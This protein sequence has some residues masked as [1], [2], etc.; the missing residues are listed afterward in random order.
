MNQS[1]NSSRSWLLIF[2]M[3]LQRK[4]VAT[5]LSKLNF[6]LHISLHYYDNSKLVQQTDQMIDL[7]EKGMAKYGQRPNKN[8]LC[9]S[10][11][12]NF[13]EFNDKKYINYI[14]T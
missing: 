4:N 12:H 10:G 14:K 2:N 6:Q 1:H 3:E 8:K 13:S 7:T 5:K 11:F 9:R